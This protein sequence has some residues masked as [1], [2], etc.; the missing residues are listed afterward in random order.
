LSLVAKI[1]VG[2]SLRLRDHILPIRKLADW[3]V[4]Q[5]FWSRPLVSTANSFADHLSKL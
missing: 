4:V 5:L 1:F 3:R 2:A